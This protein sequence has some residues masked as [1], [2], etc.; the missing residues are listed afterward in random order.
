[1]NHHESRT[2]R[3]HLGGYLI[4]ACAIASGAPAGFGQRADE[5]VKQLEG[6][7]IEEHVNAQVPLDLTFLNEDGKRVRLRDY[8][9]GDKPVLL[10][11]NYYA[12]PML[13]TLQLNG[14]IDG[15]RE[16]KWTPGDE[17]EVVTVSIDPK[18]T[19]NLA[20]L[21]KQNYMKDYGRPGAAK[22]WHFL[23]GNQ[24]NI[25]ALADTVGFQYRYDP[26]T[27]QYAHAAATMVCM[28]DGRLSRYLY[29]V[30]YDPQTLRLSMVEASEGKVGST[31]DRVLL[32]CC[33]YDAS[34]GKYAPAA[35]N[36]V[37][38]GGV[39]TMVVLA[40]VLIVFWRRERRRAAN[41][42]AQPQT[43]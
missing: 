37:R 10:T 22:G 15:F 7:G 4:A 33:Q 43:S 28:P 20:R 1:M 13:C 27:K 14:L 12:C 34:K 2:G 24:K 9:T 42:K 25:T 6:V 23:V 21:K 19:P 40:V 17:F 30:V 36:L 18:E 35:F 5:K 38:G 11:L 31:L 16:M 3:G 39:L 32:F 29:G 41:A 26:D 8:F